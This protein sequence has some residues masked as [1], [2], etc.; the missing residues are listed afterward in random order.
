MHVGRTLTGLVAHQ[1]ETY[2]PATQRTREKLLF[3][4]LAKGHESFR[5]FYRGHGIASVLIK[6][7]INI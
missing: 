5:V 1:A 6:E 7:F 4:D 2:R 3:F